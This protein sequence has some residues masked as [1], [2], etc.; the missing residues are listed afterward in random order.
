RNAA[1]FKFHL[2][3]FREWG[4][5]QLLIHPLQAFPLLATQLTLLAFR[6]SRG[7]NDE[8]AELYVNDLGD[9]SGVLALRP[10]RVQPS[11]ELAAF[12][13][14]ELSR[15]QDRVD[16]AFGYRPELAKP[17]RSPAQQR[18]L[19]ERYRLLWDITIDGRLTAANRPALATREQRWQELTCAF[20]FWSGARQ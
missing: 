8:G 16:P 9:R 12:L 1:F 13:S 19:V 10:E 11:N 17:Y 3:W 2:D 18:R 5:E 6:R 4:F 14:H 15:R 7:R 20:S